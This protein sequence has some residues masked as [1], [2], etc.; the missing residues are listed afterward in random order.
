MQVAKY[1]KERGEE[2]DFDSFEVQE[3]SKKHGLELFMLYIFYDHDF[4]KELRIK[5]LVFRNFIEKIQSGYL[6][7]P[8]HTS[9]HALD[10]TQVYIILLFQLIHFSRQLIF[11]FTSAR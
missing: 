1:F 6:N 7:N 3:L 2:I 8:Y 11:L 5:P 10:V 9:T 4:F